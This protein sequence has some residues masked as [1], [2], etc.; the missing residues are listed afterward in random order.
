MMRGLAATLAA[1]CLAWMV[2]E[3]APTDPPPPATVRP[4]PRTED[5]AASRQA[6]V[7]E[8]VQQSTTPVP[9][10]FVGDS[11]TQGWESEGVA[12]WQE[13]MAPLGAMN[14]GVGGD[15]TEHVL[16]RLEQAPLSRLQPRV[17]V[18]MIG[19][20]NASSGRDRGEQIV[21]GIRAIVRL[22]QEQCPQ[23]CIV[24]LDIPPR[25]QAMNPVR[26]LVLQVNQALAA[27][28]WPEQVTWLACGDRLVLPD[29]SIDPAIMPDLLHLSPEGYRRWARSILP[30]I[31]AH[32]EPR[33]APLVPEE[34]VPP[35]APPGPGDPPSGT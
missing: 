35:T 10:V 26:G 2:P 32:L 3:E 7:L 14:L 29:G 19:T 22:L 13:R 24:L 12:I 31:T 8:R 16:W 30:V 18:L 20:N 6:E 33:A 25:G 23:A 9:V 21:Q 4:T 28:A 17:I 27:T 5:W 15:R 34:P 1:C 11:I